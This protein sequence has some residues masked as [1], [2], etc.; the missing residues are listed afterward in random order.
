MFAEE[1][2]YAFHFSQE[3]CVAG[4]AVPGQGIVFWGEVAGQGVEGSP[5]HTELS[6]QNDQT[7]NTSGK[8]MPFQSALAIS[9][10]ALHTLQLF[11]PQFFKLVTFSC[12]AYL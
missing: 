8:T 1:V 3:A 2:H 6:F 9:R 12:I 7:T 5:V 4:V 10:P 11:T